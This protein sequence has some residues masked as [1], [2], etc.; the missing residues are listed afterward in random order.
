MRFVAYFPA[1]ALRPVMCKFLDLLLV[2]EILEA[3]FSLLRRTNLIRFRNLQFGSYEPS[4]TGLLNHRFLKHGRLVH[5]NLS[6]TASKFSLTGATLS[7]NLHATGRRAPD[8][9]KYEKCFTA[10][11]GGPERSEKGIHERISLPR[12]LEPG[13]KCLE[14]SH[15]WPSAALKRRPVR[16]TSHHARDAEWVG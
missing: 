16:G 9:K 7:G 14:E 8:T 12:R 13:F 4:L 3:I 15:M 6:K 10:Q 2:R 5:S 1:G 11:V